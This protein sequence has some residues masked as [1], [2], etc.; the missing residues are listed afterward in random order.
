MLCNYCL[1]EA[2]QI[3]QSSS[4]A[5]EVA[6][7]D[8][9]RAE[10]MH[11]ANAVGVSQL[12][13]PYQCQSSAVWSARLHPCAVDEGWMCSQ[14]SHPT[15]TDVHDVWYQPRLDKTLRWLNIN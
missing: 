12:P 8:T 7:G 15:L 9:K 4:L 11:S 2:L 10:E 5:A 14:V 13:K 6:P 1:R 3:P